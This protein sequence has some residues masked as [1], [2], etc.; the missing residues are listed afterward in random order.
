MDG[1][2]Y[3]LGLRPQQVAPNLFLVGDPARAYR[4]AARFDRVDHEVKHREFVALTGTH[5]GLPVTALGTGIGPDNVE[6]ALVEAWALATLDLA[7]RERRPAAGP[8]AARPLS[9]LR[10]GTSGGTRE[11]LPVGTL[12]VSS[13]AIGLDTTGLFYDTPPADA[14]VTAL[15]QAAHAAITAGV[16]AGSRF[17]GAFSRTRRRRRRRSSPPSSGTR[18]PR[19]WPT[20]PARRSRR[21]ASSHLRGASSTAH[22]H[23]RGRQATARTDRSGRRAGAH[24]GDGVEPAVPPGRAARRPR[25]HDLPDDQQPRG[26]RLGARPRSARRAGDRRRTRRDARRGG[27]GREVAWICRRSSRARQGAAQRAERAGA[28]VRW[29]ASVAVKVARRCV[30]AGA[31]IA[32]GDLL[33]LVDGSP[34]S[35]ESPKLYD[36]RAAK[37]LYLLLEGTARARRARHHRH[38]HRREPRLH[39]RGGPLPL[40]AGRSRPRRARAA[41]GARRLRRAAAA[42]PR[43]ARG[44]RQSGH[45]RAALRGRGALGEGSVPAGARAHPAV[46]RPLRRRLDHEL[47]SH[48]DALPRARGAAAGP[49]GPGLQKLKDAFAYSPLESTADAIA[50]VTGVRPP[51][52]A[53][54][55][56]RAGAFR[57][58]TCCRRSRARRRRCRSAT[59]CAPWRRT[60]SCACACSRATQQRALRRLPQPLRQLRELLRAVSRRP[61]RAHG[62]AQALP[63][64]RAP[65]PARGRGARAAAALRAAAGAGRG[66]GEPR[67][68]EARSSCC[69]TPRARSCSRASSTASSSGTLSRARPVASAR[70]RCGAAAAP[71]AAACA[72]AC[73]ARGGVVDERGDDRRRLHQVAAPGGGRRRRCSEWWVRVPVVHRV[74]DELEARQADRVERQVVGAAGVADRERGARGRG[75]A[76]ATLEDRPH[77]VVAL[78]V[79]AA[80]LAG[81]VVEVE[82]GRPASRGRGRAASSRVGEVLL[83]RTR[84]SRAGPAPRRPTARGAPCGRAAGRA[85]SGCASPRAPRRSPR[86]CRW[87][88]CRRATSRGARPSITISSARL[89]PGISAITLA[90]S[91]VLV[92]H[93]DGDLELDPHRLLPLD[94]PRDAAVALRREHHH[95]RRHRRA[96]AP[97]ARPAPRTRRRPLPRP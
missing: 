47:S 53:A 49:Q 95:R 50:E 8:E 60:S 52:N 85:P 91:M 23:R 51:S 78:Q 34:A 55:S 81:A 87:R 80:D 6:I 45:A 67:L 64:P 17:A 46:P 27:R 9:V 5:R 43:R 89:P 93:L 32:R 20:R 7:T 77:H 48:R 44:R 79:D 84:A 2:V 96:G 31:G 19:A 1:C 66:V 4:V 12:V 92:R 13:Y 35:R 73:P 62:G 70:L 18:T 40:Q 58:S 15:E 3:H 22:E 30:A 83:R 29:A 94:E 38:R 82:V 36:H 11:D 21:L 10:V 25:R 37:R 72:A 16:R 59:R 88:R 56:G 28:T 33:S 90:A 71:S 69:S 57:S 86:R 97:E 42:Q 68:P 63:R 26:P 39:R 74:L 14:T 24:H 54:G 65:L 75:T 41:L 61:A 76:A